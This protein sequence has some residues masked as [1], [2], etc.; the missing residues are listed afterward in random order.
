MQKTTKRGE[1]EF[2]SR[3]IRRTAV[4][5]RL[6]AQLQSG[7]KPTKDVQIP[8]LKATVPLNL[9]DRERIDREL[10]VLKAKV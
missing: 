6:E 3:T 7:V 10:A 8:G 9:K 4:I 1:K 5:N 2:S